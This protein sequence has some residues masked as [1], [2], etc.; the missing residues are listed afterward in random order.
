MNQTSNTTKMKTEYSDIAIRFKE[1]R[2]NNKLTQKEF[3]KAVGLSAPA[4]GAIENGL[5]TP[6][7]NVMRLLK[8]KF[9]IDYSYL[10]D[11]DYSENIKNLRQENLQLK[12]EVDRLTKVVDKLVK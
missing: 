3:G 12:K 2:I 5:Y 8:D 9:N 6:N 11:G 4:I 1:I 7:F 10:I